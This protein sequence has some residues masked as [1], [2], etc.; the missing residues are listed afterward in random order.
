MPTI[1]SGFVKVMNGK[2]HSAL[3]MA[4]L[5]DAL[6]LSD[7]PMPLPLFSIL[8]MT[9]SLI[10]W[11]YAFLFIWT[12]F[13]SIPMTL[14]TTGNMSERCSDNSDSTDFMPMPTSVPS[15][16]TP[17][18]T[19]GISYLWTVV[20]WT[21]EKSRRFKIGP[22]LVKLKDIHLSSALRTFIGVLFTIISSA[23]FH[24]HTWLG[25]ELHGISPIPA[26]LPLRPL[27][28]CSWLLW[29]LSNG[30]LVHHSLWKLTP[31]TMPSA[32]Y[33]LQSLTLI[34]KYIWSCFTPGLSH[35]RSWITMFTTKNSCV[36]LSCKELNKWRWL[37]GWICKSGMMSG[38][39][40]IGM[41][42]S[43]RDLASTYVLRHLA[44]LCP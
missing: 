41:D 3:A 39:P 30:F 10:S 13:W 31:P 2:L 12:T 25:K 34:M 23:Q 4:L 16:R 1:L 32:P 8:W 11:I 35:L 17:L 26:G 33:Y 40:D 37:M 7:L 36:K 15:I 29:S 19:L 6:C 42:W 14:M 9:F 24:W 27:R 38:C 20:W 5:S 28:R 22:S 21:P 43:Q 18:S 44:L